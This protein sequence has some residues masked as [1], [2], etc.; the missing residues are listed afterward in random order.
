MTR[1]LNIFER[2]A[3]YTLPIWI[4][5]IVYTFI[6]FIKW[7][8]TIIPHIM[9]PGFFILF[10]FNINDM[11]SVSLNSI[12]IVNCVFYY[13]FILITIYICNRIKS[14]NKASIK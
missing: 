3:I 5:L 1:K 8:S 4:I 14:K 9:D 11:R 2:A 10:L 13:L 7:N 12:L 6:F